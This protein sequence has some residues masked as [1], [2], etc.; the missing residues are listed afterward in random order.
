MQEW[1][2][3]VHAVSFGKSGE[4]DRLVVKKRSSNLKCVVVCINAHIFTGLTVTWKCNTDSNLTDIY[5]EPE[6]EWKP[7]KALT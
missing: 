6:D 4:R 2:A 5:Y 1:S 7:D 3:T